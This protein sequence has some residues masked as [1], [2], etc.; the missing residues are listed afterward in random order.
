MNHYE[1]V[2]DA[3]R[4]NL[5][6]SVRLAAKSLENANRVFQHSLDL[7]TTMARESAEMLKP[8]AA[9][10]KDP[11]ELLAGIEKGRQFC[12]RQLERCV[13]LW[14]ESFDAGME[15]QSELARIIQSN[16][17]N[18]TRAATLAGTT[19][20]AGSAAEKSE[21]ASPAKRGRTGAT[22]Q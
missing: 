4:T 10:A 12:G 5:D 20:T 21:Q 18:A 6:A 1:Q 19:F 3:N 14:R 8:D 11:V 7:A 16:L 15:T 17:A 22:H 13:A 2:M 9:G